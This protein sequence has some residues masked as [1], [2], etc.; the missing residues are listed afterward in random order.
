[1]TINQ[2]PPIVLLKNSEAAYSTLTTSLL[3]CWHYYITGLPLY[4]LWN[5][6]NWVCAKTFFILART[7]LDKC[8][9]IPSPVRPSISL[10]PPYTS[11][12]VG[13]LCWWRFICII[14]I[15]YYFAKRSNYIGFSLYFS[16]ATRK[17]S[18]VVG[19]PTP[20]QMFMRYYRSATLYYITFIIRVYC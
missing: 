4:C 1:L 14:I 17:S 12:I 9:R 20:Y 18:F 2:H 19:I 5:R 15:H 8:I 13:L 16:R 11:A 7:R 10:R 3:E 6:S